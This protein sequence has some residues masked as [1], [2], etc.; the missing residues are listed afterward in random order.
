MAR[1][2]IR[3]DKVEAGVVAVAEEEAAAFATGRKAISGAGFGDGVEFNKK[4]DIWL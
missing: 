4:R 2:R 3:V 1:Q